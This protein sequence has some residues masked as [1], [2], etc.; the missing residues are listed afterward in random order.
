MNLDNK[1]GKHFC[2]HCVIIMYGEFSALFS[3]KVRGVPTIQRFLIYTSVGNFI[4]DLSEC[5]L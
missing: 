2:S 4:W 1:N 5:L 3:L